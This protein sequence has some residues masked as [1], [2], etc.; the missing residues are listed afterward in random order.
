M[1]QGISQVVVWFLLAAVPVQCYSAAGMLFCTQEAQSSAGR[2]IDADAKALPDHHQHRLSDMSQAGSG[3]D[4]LVHEH[5]GS[6]DHGLKHKSSKCSISAPCCVGGTLLPSSP[7]VP[8]PPFANVAPEPR[9]AAS[10]FTRT[11]DG[12]DRPPRTDLS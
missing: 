5:H 8:V 10:F 2:S 9:A 12:L 7:V 4:Q 11:I 1:F 6:H 3:A